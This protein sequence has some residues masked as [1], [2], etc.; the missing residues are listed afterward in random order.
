MVRYLLIKMNKFTE[1]LWGNFRYRP[2][3]GRKV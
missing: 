2:S 1:E 3:A